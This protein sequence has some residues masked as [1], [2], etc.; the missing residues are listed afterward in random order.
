LAF[1]IT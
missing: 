1:N